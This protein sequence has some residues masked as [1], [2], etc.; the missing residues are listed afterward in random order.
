MPNYNTVASI[1]IPAIYPG[2]QILLFNAEQPTP[3]QA[4]QQVALGNAYDNAST[5][6]VS[7]EIQFSGAPGAFSIQPQVADTDTDTAYVSE[8]AAVTTVNS[9]NYARVELT[10]I[11]A[12]FLRVLLSSR[13]NA[14]NLTVK[15]SR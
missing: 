12:K 14:V 2:D 5:Q 10:S 3:P 15:V 9:S 4:S 1:P 11:K 8:G 13:T 6:A 7:I